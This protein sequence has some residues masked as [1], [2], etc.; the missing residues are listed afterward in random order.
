[1]ATGRMLRCY[2]W[3]SAVDQ[4]PIA[5]LCHGRRPAFVAAAKLASGL[6]EPVP[7][8][9]LLAALAAWN[10]RRVGWRAA[11]TPCFRVATGMLARR[12]LSQLIAR[13]RPPAALWLTEPEGFSFPSKHTTLA[14]LTAAVCSLDVHGRPGYA[15]PL[16]AAGAVG[17]S[18]VYLG[19]HW[20]TDIVGGW[21]FA[22][23][24]FRM[25]ESPSPHRLRHAHRLRHYHRESGD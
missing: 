17:A 25:T 23:G 9:V 11:A 19:V 5:R 3:L 22:E 18:R 1:M 12:G 6:A 20:P 2:G 16:V 7:S 15:A 13:P 14:A 21:L 4:K 10:T 24:W 8:A